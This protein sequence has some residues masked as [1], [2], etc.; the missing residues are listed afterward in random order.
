MVDLLAR[1]LPEHPDETA[2]VLV[3]RNKRGYEIVDALKS[4]HNPG[5]EYVEL[6]QSTTSTREAA[7]A[8]GNLLQYL[9]AAEFA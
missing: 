5:I 9:G 8:L 3:P 7:G 1:W 4:L 2:A 6:L